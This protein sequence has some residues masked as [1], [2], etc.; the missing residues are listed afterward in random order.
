MYT[1]G[2][3]IISEKRQFYFDRDSDNS[4]YKKETNTNN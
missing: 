2:F 3:T 4:C 1:E